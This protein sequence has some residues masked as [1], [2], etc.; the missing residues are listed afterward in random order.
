LYRAIAQFTRTVNVLGTKLG[1]KIVLKG[2]PTRS[3][4]AFLQLWPNGSMDQ[5]TTW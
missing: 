5:D 2:I 4:V 3:S 1:I